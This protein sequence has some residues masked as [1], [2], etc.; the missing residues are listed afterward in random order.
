MFFSKS[1]QTQL[2][3]PLKIN[4]STKNPY[5]QTETTTNNQNNHHNHS[6][7]QPQQPQI[8][9]KNPPPIN[10]APPTAESQTQTQGAF[11]CRK[12]IS[13]KYIFSG[14]ANFRK[15]KMFSAVW[16]SRKSFSGKLI[17]MFGSSKHFTEI[18]LRKINSSV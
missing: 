14:N 1:R 7:H 16:L 18:V 6:H 13:G 2:T 5:P 8:T 3:N 11:G 9:T 10:L 15:R 17:P 4:L 12:T